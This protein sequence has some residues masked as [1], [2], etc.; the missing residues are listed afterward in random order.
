MYEY[1]EPGRFG[2]Y[3]WTEKEGMP[4]WHGDGSKPRAEGDEEDRAKSDQT[5]RKPEDKADDQPKRKPEDQADNQPRRKPD[6]QGG[7][8]P[9]RKPRA[10]AK[11]DDRTKA[12]P[13]GDPSAPRP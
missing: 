4:F 7:N 6:D 5:K 9:K 11:G 2:D 3:G 1:R 10:K 13:E 8:Q 12:Q